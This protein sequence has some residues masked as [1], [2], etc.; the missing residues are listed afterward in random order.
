VCGLFNAQSWS[1]ISTLDFICSKLIELAEAASKSDQ[2]VK[3]P[4]ES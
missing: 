3:R 4:L 2:K 1:E